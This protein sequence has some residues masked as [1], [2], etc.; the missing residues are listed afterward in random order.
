MCITFSSGVGAWISLRD[1]VESKAYFLDFSLFLLIRC[2]ELRTFYFVKQCF[3]F[4]FG[5]VN[6]ALTYKFFIHL[7][8]MK[9]RWKN[10]T[11]NRYSSNISFEKWNSMNN[12]DFKSL[13]YYFFDRTCIILFFIAEISM[14][15]IFL[16]LLFVH[17]IINLVSLQQIYWRYLSFN[18]W[19]VIK[20][21]FISWKYQLTRE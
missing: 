13:E 11:I 3:G 10:E 14:E 9:R 5:M 17:V 4:L 6:K 21:P 2:W 1:V 12:I 15:N 8:W 20:K 19:N 18:Q 7:N 16:L